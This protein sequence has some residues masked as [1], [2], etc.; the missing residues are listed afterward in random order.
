MLKAQPHWRSVF[1]KKWGRAACSRSLGGPMLNI[2]IN[3]TWKE[4]NLFPTVNYLI[5]CLFKLH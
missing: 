5:G 1:P 2:C 3:T 4:E